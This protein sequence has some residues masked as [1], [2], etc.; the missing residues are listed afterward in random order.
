MTSPLPFKINVSCDSCIIPHTVYQSK[1]TPFLG[2]GMTLVTLTPAL[3]LLPAECQSTVSVAP[4]PPSTWLMRSN[5]ELHSRL[6][7]G[8]RDFI[9]RT[10]C[11]GYVSANAV[12]Q[13][14]IAC[15]MLEC[16][17]RMKE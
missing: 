7:K 17:G 13:Q 1:I 8:A 14:A 4:P 11:R 2:G 3:V 15:F 9:H 16:M 6:N 12:K 5:D 10:D